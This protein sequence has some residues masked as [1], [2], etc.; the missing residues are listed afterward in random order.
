MINQRQSRAWPHWLGLV[1]AAALTTLMSG[2]WPTVPALDAAPP[3]RQLEQA[4]SASGWRGSYFAN[5]S[6]SGEPALVRLDSTIDFDWG[7]KAPATNLPADGFSVR[8]TADLRANFS[9]PYIFSVTSNDGARL[10]LD[11]RL[12]IDD[13]T[14]HVSR[15]STGTV[16]LEAGRWY[17]ITLEYYEGVR[18]AAVRLAYSSPSTPWQIIP[19]A[20]VRSDIPADPGLSASPSRT[21]TPAATLTVT[22]TR[23]ATVTPSPSSTP[24]V[25]ATPTATATPLATVTV[26]L[27]GKDGRAAVSVLLASYDLQA[28]LPESRNLAYQPRQFTSGLVAADAS[29]GAQ[30]IDDAGPYSGWDVLALPNEGIMRISDRSDWIILRLNRPAILVV[31]WRWGSMPPAWLASWEPGSNVVINGAPYPTFTRRADAGE[32]ALGGVYDPGTVPGEHTTRDTYWVLLGEEDGRPSAAPPVPAGLPVPQPNETCPAWVHDQYV[33]TGPDGRTYPTWHP[34]TDPVYW[35]YFRHDH[36][37][38]PALFA[39]GY[40]PA[41]GYVPAIAGVNE[42]HPGFKNYIFDDLRGRRWLITHHFGTGSTQRACVRFHA[43]D[44]AVAA[45]GSGELLAELHFMADFGKSVVNTTGESLIPPDCPNQA[46]QSDAAGST[47]VRMLPVITRGAVGYEPWRMDG[48]R[49]IVG[50]NGSLTLN[51]V[52]AAAICNHVTCDRPVITGETGTR[53]FFTYTSDFGITAGPHSGMF[54]TDPYGQ[55]LISAG[56]PG[57]VR[58]YVK[59]GLTLN[60][61]YHGDDQTCYA[62]DPW[63]VEYRCD[64]SLSQGLPTALERAI[65]TPN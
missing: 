15:E 20:N 65:Q 52:D 23:T 36:G 19:S 34:Q 16:T 55:S 30:R 60:L 31:V 13:W 33:T 48:A 2:G 24:P 35:C 57:A 25:T 53:R 18:E 40:R 17:Q 12:L 56:Q 5:P 42:P 43:I 62:T 8:W 54:Y 27:T 49:I 38:D 29:W 6:L 50:L 41:F 28:P 1:M 39:A 10:W 22:T 21:A 44:I 45:V 63:R 32:V 26:T 14:D 61:P 7:E 3:L 46:A 58:Q 4:A 47:G 11:G 64:A 37:S 9:E 59:P 51:T